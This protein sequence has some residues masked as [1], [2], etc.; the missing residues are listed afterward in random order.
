L[1]KSWGILI[2]FF[3]MR[4]IDSLYIMHK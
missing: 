4:K 2:Y 3:S 1:I